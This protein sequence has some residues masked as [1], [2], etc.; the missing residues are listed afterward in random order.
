MSKKETANDYDNVVCEYDNYRIIRCKDDIQFI[1]QRKVREEPHKAW[2]KA[3]AY[4][5]NEKALLPV[6]QRPSLGIPQGLVAAWEN[7]RG[8]E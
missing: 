3:L 2:A 5:S 8:S 1:V 7:A 4:I 6:L